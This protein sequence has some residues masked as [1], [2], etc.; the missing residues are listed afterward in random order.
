MA[1]EHDAIGDVRGKGLMIGVELVEDR[2]TKVRA[3][4]LRDDVINRCFEK[5]L[6]ILGCGPNTVR[7]APP[8][9]IDEGTADKALEIFEDV[10]TELAG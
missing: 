7:W 8:L 9:V 5:G 10:L 3:K 2:G 6:L 4:K 1:E